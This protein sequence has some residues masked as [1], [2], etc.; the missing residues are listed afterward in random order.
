[1]RFAIALGGAAC[2]QDTPGFQVFVNETRNA[3]VTILWEL[4]AP[5]ATV[6]LTTQE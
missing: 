3:L 6:P 5:I 2:T 1:M 4:L